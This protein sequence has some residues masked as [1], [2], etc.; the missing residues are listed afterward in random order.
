MTSDTRAELQKLPNVVEVY[1]ELRFTADLRFADSGHV[2][3]ATSV[4]QSEKG[5]GPFDGLQGT[6]FSAPDAA[7]VI[8]HKDL[9]Q[10]M[11][12]EAKIQPSALIGQKV[13]LRYPRRERVPNTGTSPED[14][15]ANDEFEPGFRTIPSQANVTIVGIVQNEEAGPGGLGGVRMFLPLGFVDKLNPVQTSDLRAMVQSPNQ[16]IYASLTV[17]VNDPK[18]VTSLEDSIKQMGYATFSLF[19]AAQSLHRFFAVLDTF[20]G[21]FRQPG[22]GGGFARNYQHAGDGDSGAAARN[23]QC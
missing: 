21:D 16:Q 19:D 9:A 13:I 7:E 15:A 10:Q 4:P 18:N 2:Y 23:R 8:L 14:M 3:S 1:P 11:A 22:A 17:K 12:D 6:F 20:S 5:S